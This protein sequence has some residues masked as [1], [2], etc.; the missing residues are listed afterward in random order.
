MFFAS[1]SIILL[2]MYYAV[3][4]SLPLRY[5]SLFYLKLHGPINVSNLQ[6]QDNHLDFDLTY[7]TE[8]LMQLL[9][10]HCHTERNIE[11]R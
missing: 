9:T 4:S 7:L 6:N 1:S 3:F 10:M 11:S 5:V 8:I 2:Y